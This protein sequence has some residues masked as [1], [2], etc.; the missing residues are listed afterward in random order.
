MSG[1]DPSRREAGEG[2][3]RRDGTLQ[4]KVTDRDPV[5]HCVCRP[6]HEVCVCRLALSKR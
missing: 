2:V 5:L 3:H 6:V 1:R 4:S